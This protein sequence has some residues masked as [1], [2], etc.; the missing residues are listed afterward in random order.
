MKYLRLILSLLVWGGALAPLQ[1]QF[2]TAQIPVLEQTLNTLHQQASF[3]GVVLLAENGKIIFQKSLGV[4]NITEQSPLTQESA[5]NLASVSK[6]FM[7]MMVMMLHDQKKWDF[8]DPVS[9]YLPEFPYP[10]INIRHLLTHTSGLP[11]YFDLVLQ[12]KNTLDTLTNQELLSLLQDK[13]PALLFAPSEKW[14]YCNTNYVLLATLIEKVAGMP[15]ETFFAQKITQPLGLKDTYIYQLTMKKS[16]Q[17]RVFG[18]KRQDGIQA[19]DDL[20]RFDGVVGDG[21][22]YASAQD[23]LKWD[24]ALYKGQLVHPN[25]WKEACT[26]VQL[27]DG[28]TAPYGFGW[29]ISEE[30]KVLSHTGGWVG[31]RNHFVRDI[32]HHQ[33]LIVLSSAGNDI[34]FVSDILKGKPIVLP[35]FQ[36]ITNVQVLDGTGSPARRADVRLKDDHI[37]EIGVLKPFVEETLTDGAGL[38]L[39]PGFIDSHSHHF[40]GLETRPEALAPINQGIT[41]IVIGQDGDGY[42]MDTIETFM[43]NRP[44][45]VNV[46]TYTGHSSLREMAMGENDLYRVS[47]PAELDQMK[48]NLQTEMVKGSLGLSTG[49]EYEAAFFC[50]RDEVIELAKLTATYGGR[51]ISHIRSED[52]NLDEAIDETIEIGRLA[53]IPVQISHIKIAKKD[54]WGQSNALLARLQ[55]AR[56]EGIDITADCYP[57]DFWN[58]TLRVLFPNRDYT[59]VESARLAVT[60]LCDPGKSVLVKYAPQKE[61]EGK[62]LSAVAAMRRESPEITLIWLV[63]TAE[64]FGQEHPDHSGG[65]EAIM[66]KSMDEQDVENF[67]R[68]NHTNICSDG[69]WRGHPRGHGAFTRVLSRF[70]RERKAFPLETAVFKMTGLAAEHLGL[71]DRGL[72]QPGYYADLVL[73]NP[74]TVQ[75]NA[76]IQQPGALSTGIEKVWVNGVLV[77]QGQ[78]ATGE[79]PGMLIKRTET[80][81]K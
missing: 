52:I 33:T 46:A 10:N 14:E 54:Q 15:I 71:N 24:E 25:T 55:Q 75:D 32:A 41:T 62:T 73:F 6:Q 69:A 45:A 20:M 35:K 59:N 26:P 58:S 1:A 38:S 2:K 49:L 31:F 78:K 53:K 29:F 19:P 60:Q 22:I 18:F 51:Y 76:N 4:A 63:Q 50:N 27:K 40:G 43:K 65:I 8:D 13:K 7:A 74:A 77:Y 81:A 21:N 66:G 47:T 16:P 3:N 70:V 72:I 23:L 30:G 44:V 36:L 67:L 68:W 57:Y 17:N 42:P 64:K 11:E 56:A 28:S 39:A 79:F 34:R 37:F 9:K 5:F 61:Y 80:P 48:K 12:Y